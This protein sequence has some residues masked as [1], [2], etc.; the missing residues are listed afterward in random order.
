MW[1][2]VLRRRCTTIL[3]AGFSGLKPPESMDVR[4]RCLLCVVQVALSPTA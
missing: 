2:C 1:P 3:A 4:L